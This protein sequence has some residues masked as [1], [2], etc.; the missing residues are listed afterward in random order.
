MKKSTLSDNTPTK[1]NPEKETNPDEVGEKEMSDVD[2]F[3]SDPGVVEVRNTEFSDMEEVK[4][5]TEK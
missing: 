3:G 1:E 4:V 2:S 5:S